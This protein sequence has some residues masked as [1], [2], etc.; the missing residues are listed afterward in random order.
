MSSAL[1]RAVS[2]TSRNKAVWRFKSSLIA[3]TAA[4]ISLPEAASMVG[5]SVNSRLTAAERSAS[6]SATSVPALTICAALRDKTA[7]IVAV[8][9]LKPSQ[10]FC[11][12]VF[13]TVP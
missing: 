8:W 3:V 9:R 6:E 4:S 11:A 5:C 7:S 13:K 1:T 12:A 10:M 2:A